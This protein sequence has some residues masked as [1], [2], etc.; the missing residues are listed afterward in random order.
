MKADGR[1]VADLL[2]GSVARKVA[3]YASCSVLVVKDPAGSR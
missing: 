2:L 1:G 3:R